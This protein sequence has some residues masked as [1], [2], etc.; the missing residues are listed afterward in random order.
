V[1]GWSLE[2]VWKT[3]ALIRSGRIA[4]TTHDFHFLCFLLSPVFFFCTVFTF[5]AGVGI[6]VVEDV[7][8]ACDMAVCFS[9]YLNVQNV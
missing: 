9:P 5:A 8:F 3:S 4:L 7:R 1:G 6:V 2:I